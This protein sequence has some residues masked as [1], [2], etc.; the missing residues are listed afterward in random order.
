MMGTTCGLV[1]AAHRS[2]EQAN[3]RLIDRL[4]SGPNVV[5]KPTQLGQAAINSIAQADPV[6]AA[7]ARA[8]FT[9]E[10]D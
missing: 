10:L 8:A 7:A 5:P 6:L 1:V 9:T 4:F 2:H 3:E